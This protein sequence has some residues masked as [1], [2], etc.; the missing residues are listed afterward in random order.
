MPRVIA[1]RY[2][3]IE[4][5]GRGGMGAVWR[6]RDRTLGR[7]VAVKEVTPPPGLE[8]DQRARLYA[9]TIREARSA[10]RL[11]HPGIVTV[12]DVVEEDGRPWIVMRL[13][14][15]PSLDRVLAEQG[16]LPAPR[17]AAIGARLVEAL[18]TAHAAGVVHRDVKPGNVLL[19]GDRAVLTDFGIAAMD[20]E[21]TLTRG[22]S[23]IGSPAYL[24]PEQARG[25]EIGPAADL[26]SL[27]A[28][29]YAAVEGRPP[30][31]RPDLWSMLAAVMSDDPD[32]PE[33]AGPLRPVLDGLLRKEP[34]ERMGAQEAGRLLAAIARGGPVPAGGWEPGIGAGEKDVSLGSPLRVPPPEGRP[35]P[36]PRWWILQVAAGLAVVIVAAAVIAAALMDGG[37]TPGGTSTSPPGRSASPSGG[38]AV[39]PA[40][41]FE[42]YRAESFV[43][44]VPKG[45]RREQSGR[46]LSFT[47]RAQGR[48]RGIT[49]DPLG[50]ALG[51]AGDHLA[52]ASKSFESQYTDYEQLS[53][54][55][56]IPYLGGRAAELE[57]TF[58]ENGIPGHCRVRVF[59]L[60]GGF[61]MITMLAQESDWAGSRPYFETFLR[62]FK[63]V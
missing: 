37:R 57:F 9:R 56:N 42:E 21:E 2:E 18:S 33:H 35:A 38:A 40:P 31:R 5:L 55:E 11:D 43:V 19:D 25:R 22:G 7:D 17:V 63:P 8:E 58:T 53:L 29:L 10:A 49:V 20:G 46:T 54:R 50:A 23:L 3:L 24:S 39:G 59:P 26:W 12:H 27:G 44:H 52:S 45:W 1:G 14:R 32:P 61:H 60:G 51:D 6:A 13:V 47:D 41:G 28:T 4:L 30:F 36:A 15:A 62:T 48:R 16:R 34:A